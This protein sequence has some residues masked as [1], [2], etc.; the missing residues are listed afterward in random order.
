M[1]IQLISFSGDMNP[2]YQIASVIDIINNSEADLILFPGHTLRDENDRRYVEDSLTNK[3]VTAIIEMEEDGVMCSPNELFIYRKGKFEDMYTSQVFSKAEEVN[4]KT[5]LME[6]LLDELPR[7]QFTCCEKRFTV[8]QCGESAIVS[9]KG[10]GEFQ[11]KDNPGL[12]ERF[13]KLMEETDVFLNP[14][15][16]IQGHQNHISRRRSVLSSGGRYYL[17]ASCT[18]KWEQELTLKSLQYICHDGSELTIKPEVHK[19][20]RYVSRTIEI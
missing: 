10:G 18:K 17:S 14:I 6:K 9:D 20:E 5:V 16:T 19:D 15:H 7:R 11:F 12:N 8:L 2:N 13:E 1:K 3:K 4:G